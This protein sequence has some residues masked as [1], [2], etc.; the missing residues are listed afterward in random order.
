MIMRLIVSI[1]FFLNKNWPSCR[2][3]IDAT[4]FMSMRERAVLELTHIMADM[5]AGGIFSAMGR[6]IGIVA[7]ATVGGFF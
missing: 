4:E 2:T 1:T 3:A 6:I 7:G 5:R